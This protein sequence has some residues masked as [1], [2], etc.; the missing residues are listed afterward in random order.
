LKKRG[1]RLNPRNG[2]NPKSQNH[3]EKPE[4]GRENTWG[5]TGTLK[6]YIQYTENGEETVYK[7]QP[8]ASNE[9]GGGG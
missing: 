1:E 9:H 8:H 3:S 7:I 6:S 4:R 5:D 2:I